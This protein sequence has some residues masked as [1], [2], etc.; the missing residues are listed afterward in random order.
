MKYSLIVILLFSFI[1][2]QAQVKGTVKDNL[3]DPIAGANLFW[4][5]T[6]QG[7]TTSADGTFSLSKP[8]DKH[9]LVVSFIGF[10][11]D[12]IHVSNRNETLDIVLREG[13]ELSE[14]NVVS[15]KLG[16]MKLRNSVMNEDMISSAEL[17]R[18]ACC[19]LGESFVTNP[20][21]DVTY[22]DAATGAKQIKLL[23]LSGTY[24]QMM[25]ENMPNFRGIS[26]LYG[27]NYVPGP[28]MSAISVSKGA[29]SVINGYEAIAGQIR[30]DYKKPATSE[31]IFVNA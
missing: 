22:S 5:G 8:N 30:V 1:A 2:L 9:M 12:T 18:A 29:G 31:N 28:W 11:N 26:A 24:V 27:L 16:T 23:G 14:V 15:R 17:N 4:Q 21:V 3:G 25:T 13:V 20:S 19:N 7:T 10:E 6:T